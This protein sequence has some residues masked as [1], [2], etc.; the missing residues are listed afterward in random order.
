MAN[1]IPH[2][3]VFTLI[4]LSLSLVQQTERVLEGALRSI[5]KS[6]AL[7]VEALLQRRKVGAG[8]PTLGEFIREL[9]KHSD[10]EPQFSSR[11]RRFLQMRNVFVHD[12]SE[13]DGWN[14]QTNKGK[15]KAIEFLVELQMLSLHLSGVFLSLFTVA[16][17]QNFG[18]ELF[19]DNE[20]MKLIE[21]HCGPIASTILAKR[22]R[23]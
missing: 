15:E 11:L 4:G 12:F 1:E 10:L 14:L 22:R 2:L 8:H 19:A 16:A 9:R 17:R 5:F 21:K 3:R 13:I 20:V 6:Q 23:T 18:T 7:T